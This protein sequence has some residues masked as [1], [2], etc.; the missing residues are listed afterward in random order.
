VQLS[1]LQLAGRSSGIDGDAAD[2]LGAPA[3]PNTWPPER[4][5]HPGCV[6]PRPQWL[7]AALARLKA[8]G[9]TVTNAVPEGG[10]IPLVNRKIV[11]ALLNDL[12]VE[13]RGKVLKVG[14]GLCLGRSPPPFSP[15]Q[16]HHFGPP[17][18]SR[19][20]Q[21][22]NLTPSPGDNVARVGPTNPIPSTFSP[23]PEMRF[24]V[25]LASRAGGVPF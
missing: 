1:S 2:S 18:R 9:H 3:Q 6:N 8:E 14:A 19:F 15:P 24:A 4:Q 7:L 13:V 11:F 25:L 16:S 17:K 23:E 21:R 12:E 10:S 5:Q 20:S 22:G